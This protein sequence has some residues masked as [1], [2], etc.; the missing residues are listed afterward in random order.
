M[1][2][3]Y[4]TGGFKLNHSSSTMAME[5]IQPYLSQGLVPGMTLDYYILVYMLDL[6]RSESSS[7][8]THHQSRFVTE[9]SVM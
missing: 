8:Y 3:L 6:V 2:S 9:S 5:S 7:Y 4:A 1:I